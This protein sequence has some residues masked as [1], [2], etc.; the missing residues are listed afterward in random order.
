MKILDIPFARPI[1]VVIV[2]GILSLVGAYEYATMKYELLPPMDISYVT[3]QAIYPGASPREV[4]DQVT[5]KLEDAVSGIAHIKHVTSESLENLGF[6]MIEFDS[7]VDPNDATLDVQRAVA[8][9]QGDLPQSVKT[10]SV[11]KM[12]LEEFPI[13]QLAVTSDS[14]KGELYRLVKDD[15]KP[16]LARI[17]GIAQVT[18]L[19]GNEREIR[20]SLSR[21]KL[22]RYGIPIALVTERLAAAN[23]DFPAGNIK[24]ADGEY[25]V[26][27]AGKLKN[28]DELKRL[29]LADP[30]SAGGTEAGIVTLG[31]VADVEDSMADSQSIFRYNGKESVGISILKQ[32]GSN[33]V[34]AS[35]KVRAELAAMEGEF[36]GS[37]LRFEVAE[38]SS[39]FTLDSARDVVTDIVLAILF[40]GAIMVL[41][42][43]DLRSSFVVMMAIPTTILA[44]FIGMAIG[45]FSLNL[46]SLLALTLV[47]GILVDDSIVVIENIH[48][49]RALGASLRDA[50][51]E[52]TR[53]IAFAA[54]SVTLV[55]VMAFLPVSLGGGAIM[56]LLTQF[57]VTI[58]IATAI[59]LAVSFFVTPLLASRLMAESP[60]ITGG[61]IARISG[62]FERGYEQV[63][64]SFQSVISWTF[65]HKKATIGAAIALLVASFAL[66]ATGLVGSEFMTEID[67]GEF[68]VGIELP[69]RTTLEGNDRIVKLVER[70]LRSRPEVDRIYT[71]VGYDSQ[72]G[73]TAYKSEINVTLVPRSERA[74][75]SVAIGL[76]VESAVRKIPGVRAHV[77][78]IG[79]IDQGA[80]ESPIS[81]VA[82][83]Q[84]GDDN[85]KAANDWA[86]AMRQVEGTGEV[87]VSVTAGKPELRIDLDRAKLDDFGLSLDNVGASLRMALTGDDSLT[88]TEDG[89]DYP[90]RT[91]LD[92]EDRMDTDQLASM[93]FTNDRGRQIRLS[94]FA[95]VGDAFGPTLLTRLDRKESVTVSCQAIGRPIGDL[96]KDIRAKAA[97]ITLPKGV[98]VRAAGDLEMQGDAFGSLG[99]ALILSVVLIYAILAILF[100]SL[101]YPLSVMFSLPFAMIGG[102]FALAFTGQT[103]NIFSIMSI[104]LL[105]GLS[106]KNAILLVD[107]ALRNR[108]ER[109]MNDVAAFTEAVATRMRPIVM[110]TLAMIV[111][112]LPVAL[113][114][115]LAGEMK[116][117]MGTVLIGGLAFGLVV[118]MII[119]PVAFLALEK[120]K[121]RRGKKK[122]RAKKNTMEAIE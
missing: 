52:G 118:T 35:R 53:E 40:V 38:D 5:K 87:R 120:I 117:A 28:L 9:A 44:T 83:G 109:G 100:N 32:S 66:L 46:M 25:V 64:S 13:I 49:H 11:A 37:G 2:F 62:A 102:F 75:S 42:L 59:S 90:I 51:R 68:T 114:L 107:R 106:A 78:Q 80:S 97:E 122:A 88:F 76:D 50:A 96:D 27:I 84:N 67:R 36:K 31:D 10:P 17:G 26:R 111:G 39:V 86:A 21:E 34:E 24:A 18:I 29:A 4:E 92:R 7:E 79:L 15:V 72:A 73:S 91:V 30:A 1:A 6:V 74:R 3:V 108:A 105:M 8:T 82:L 61:V 99:F 85:L 119:V 70:E 81:Y 41:F 77:V 22:E 54:I 113:G 121:T 101:L 116:K 60:E 95:T 112:M 63:S 93:T 19:G 58:V 55:I 104:I 110:T 115:G 94:Q 45:G 23:L 20:V 12:S 89:A 48:R 16:R 65:R 14:G 33:A 47:I 71:K 98:E 103:L 69:E 43:H 57:C 56:S